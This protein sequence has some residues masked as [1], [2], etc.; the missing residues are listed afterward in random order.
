M[1]KFLERHDLQVVL[2]L[3]TLIATVRPWVSSVVEFEKMYAASH[4]AL[5]YELGLVR[6]G[7][8][9]SIMSLFVPVVSTEVVLTAAF[10]S[11]CIFLGILMAVFLNLIKNHDVDSRIFRLI[12]LFMVTPATL[13]LYA[14]DLGRFDL[15]LMMI[16]ALCFILLSKQRHLWLIP[17]LAMGAMFIHEGFLIL[18]APTLLA[19]LL[20]VYVRDARQKKMLTTL[21]ASVIAVGGSFLVLALFGT[22]TL[23]YEEFSRLVQARATFFITEL[24]M[25]ECYYGIANHLALA[26]PYL[27]DAG[28]LLNLFGAVVILSPVFLVLANLWTRVMKN[29]GSARGTCWMLLLSS[30][31]GL[32][33]VPIATDYGRWLSAV[34]F[35]NFF[36]LALLIS[37]GDLKAE[38]LEEISGG[39]FSALLVLAVVT[40]AL[41][42]PLNDWNPY[43]YQHN[44]FSSALSLI[45]V[46]AFNA[47]FVMR[48]RS[49]RKPASPR[50]GGS[51]L[52]SSL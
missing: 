22:P 36:V 12:L 18:C 41:F 17:V 47:G 13:S 44:L 28:S 5:S 9:G 24:S 16:L 52:S 23:G 6:R 19:A 51:S 38:V 46:L 40:Y 21:V 2:L 43:P 50:S 39:S 15:F 48:W 11:L 45:A 30:L 32:L 34:V 7:L 42:G 1:R 35:C 4:W 37:R 25:R 10:V 33:V 31:S 8:I 26:S 3:V 20:F 27:S 14:K 49:V 29:C